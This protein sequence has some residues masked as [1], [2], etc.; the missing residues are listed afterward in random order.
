MKKIK[1]LT[2]VVK[3]MLKIFDIRKDDQSGASNAMNLGF[4]I[5][6]FSVVCLV[7]R[8]KVCVCTHVCVVRMVPC[9]KSVLTIQAIY[10][11]TN[12]IAHGPQ[13]IVT[14]FG[15]DISR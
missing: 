8:G 11:L 14:I 5:C 13:T 15:K 6:I 9:P 1:H 7:P 12:Y 2:H 3:N 4:Q 10:C